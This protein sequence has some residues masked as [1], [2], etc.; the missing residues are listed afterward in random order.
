MGD[1]EA[2][3]RRRFSFEEDPDNYQAARPEYPRRVY[4]V[5]ADRCGLRSGAQVLEIGPGTG[6]VTHHLVAAGAHVVA[7][8]IGFGLAERLRQNTAECD[9]TVVEGDFAAV[10]VPA[11][12][13]GFD[14]A[15]CGTAFHWLD[16]EV[17]IARLARLVRAGGWLAV[18]WTVFGDPHRWPSWRGQLDAVY[19]RYLPHERRDPQ[20]LPAP[21]R[22]AER[23]RELA[24]G[25]WFAPAQVELIRWEHRLTPSAARRLWAT[26]SNVRELPN[27]LRE[28][29]LD[30]VAETVGRQPGGVVVDHYVTALYTAV[31]HP[32]PTPSHNG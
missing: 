27:Q 19:E 20:E 14:L 25:G 11:P 3:L 26:F 10:N 13:A 18:W 22:V 2:R 21:M 15:V 12:R 4:E 23:T 8:E 17:A 1:D 5:L 32:D 30:G 28:Q 9:V 29:F 6:Q 7:V 31:R 16:P 24:A